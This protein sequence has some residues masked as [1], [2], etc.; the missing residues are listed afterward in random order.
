MN[1]AKTKITFALLSSPPLFSPPKTVCQTNWAAAQLTLEEESPE[2]LQ[3][4]ASLSEKTP[5]P[6]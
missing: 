4:P 1:S 6:G 3:I 2:V 5:A